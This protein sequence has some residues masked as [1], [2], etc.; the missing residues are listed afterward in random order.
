MYQTR[1]VFRKGYRMIEGMRN[2]LNKEMLRGIQRE[3]KRERI[4]VWK[5]F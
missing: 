2:K 3:R 5:M 4:I 1:D